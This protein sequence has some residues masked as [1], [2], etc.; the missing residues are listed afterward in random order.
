MPSSKPQNI[1]DN[2]VGRNSTWSST[3]ILE[4]IGEAPSGGMSIVEYATAG[5]HQ[6]T[7]NT[8]NVSSFADTTLFLLPIA[9]AVGDQ[10]IIATNPSNDWIINQAE[11]QYIRGNGSRSTTVGTDVNLDSNSTQSSIILLCVEPNLGW[12]FIGGPVA[13]TSYSWT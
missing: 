10:L 13:V 4:R 7:T 5:P 8:V 2:I 12:Q 9:S 6:L 3:E 11:E 1:N